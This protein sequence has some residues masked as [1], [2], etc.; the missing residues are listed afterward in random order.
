MSLIIGNIITA[1]LYVFVYKFLFAQALKM[2]F[3]VLTLLSLGLTLFWFITMLPFVLL[4]TPPL[5][6][7]ISIA[8]PNFVSLSVGIISLKTV[9][10]KK[11]FG[12]SLITSGIFTLIIGLIISFSPFGAYL[13]MNFRGCFSSTVMELFQL[14]LYTCGVILSVLGFGILS[15]NLIKSEN[16]ISII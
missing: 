4:V 3:E 14:L 2:S 1:F 16:S 9:F 10:P 11:N 6:R 7:I 5:I 8:F 15:F 13:A 12:I